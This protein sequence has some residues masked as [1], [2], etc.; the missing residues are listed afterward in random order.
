M[1]KSFSLFV[2]IAF[3]CVS[4]QS[5]TGMVPVDLKAE[6]A[7][8]DNLMDKFFGAIMA[9]DVPT[10]ASFLA[11][12]TLVCGTDPSEFWNKQ[13][14]TDLWAQMVAGSVPEFKDIGE[15]IV[16][17]AADGNSAVT[18]D[19]N[20]IPAYSANLAFRN[21]AHLVKSAD[22]WKIFLFSS[23]I[24]PKNEDLPK[25]DQALNP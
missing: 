14:V 15:R 22:G 12:N 21:V 6:E 19:Q 4:C 3:L 24:I 8:V 18:V 25:L 16:K 13:Q 1:K 2:V 20:M 5:K 10:M 17:V 11:D 23:A 9:Q 7:A